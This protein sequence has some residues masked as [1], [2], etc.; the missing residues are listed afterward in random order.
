[1]APPKEPSHAEIWDDSA[2]VDSW[3]EALEEYKHYHSMHA[4]GEKVEDVLKI[5]SKQTSG[6][7]VDDSMQ[8]AQ[9]KGAV[10]GSHI[11]VDESE[12]V[13]DAPVSIPAVPE[14]DD[15]EATSAKSDQAARNQSHGPSQ[16]KG[17]PQSKG[18]AL[19]QHLIGQG[20]TS[21]FQALRHIGIRRVE[22][23]TNVWVCGS[24]RRRPEE[25][26]NVVVLCRVLYR[27]VRGP[28]AEGVVNAPS[29]C[30]A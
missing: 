26:L 30:Q 2:L 24:S 6:L 3:N 8:Y 13:Y 1:M 15:A 20:E 16:I 9:S 27:P 19:P 23:K 18:P 7:L 25:P 28:T 17:S 22:N 14:N 29:Y 10:D 5:A 21:F 4:R 12:Q 11:E